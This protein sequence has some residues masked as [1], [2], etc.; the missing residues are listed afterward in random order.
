MPNGL[1]RIISRDFPALAR[2]D[3]L[4]LARDIRQRLAR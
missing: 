2:D 4:N 3:L 1:T